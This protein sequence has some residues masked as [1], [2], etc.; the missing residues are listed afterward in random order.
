VRQGRAFGIHVILGS[1]TLSGIYT[2]AKSTLGQIG[3]RISLQCNE[4]DSHLILGED[5]TAARLLARP[6]EAIYNDM[7]GLV[8]GN[9][10][11]QVVW[12]PEDV[13]EQF[14]TQVAERAEKEKWK[15]ESPTIV[16]EGNAPAEIEN[17]LELYDLL[18]KKFDPKDEAEEAWIGES[19]S[20]KG[21]TQV[22]FI[23]NAGSNLLIVGQH[24]EAAFAVA[25]STIISMAGRHAVGNLDIAVLTPGGQDEFSEH[26]EH[27]GKALP[28]DIEIVHPNGIEDLFARIE[29]RWNDDDQQSSPLYLIVFGIQRL[30]ALRQDDEF[31]F[32]TDR[33]G[34]LPAGE[35]FANILSEGPEAGVHSIVWSDGLGTLN[36]TFS[37]KTMREFDLKVLFQM[38]AS[39]SSELIDNVTANTLGL[40][41]ALLAVESDGTIEKF[42]PYS[43]PSP[44]TLERIEELLKKRFK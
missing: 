13:Q 14:L 35:R 5:N 36:R 30:R 27:L 33:E 12:L 21:S 2:L 37:R 26:F 18:E 20:L 24:R 1:Q 22:G 4:A 19:S 41:G 32:S 42:R 8:E 40:H 9:Q 28:H 11:F 34:A 7:S 44:A 29:T 6:G 31:L 10:P 16:F 43:I 15:P 38:S 3:V 39:D 25:A 17:N 23:Q